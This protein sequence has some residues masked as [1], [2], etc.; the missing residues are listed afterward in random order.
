MKTELNGLQTD[1]IA[2]EAKKFAMIRE[3][4]ERGEIKITRARR[5]RNKKPQAGHIWYLIKFINDNK[6]IYNGAYELNQEAETEMIQKEKL[7]P[8]LLFQLANQL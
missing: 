6:W 7:I 2:A 8:F 4:Y 1:P 5:Y 3:A